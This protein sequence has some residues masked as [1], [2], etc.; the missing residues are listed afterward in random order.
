LLSLLRIVVSELSW[1]KKRSRFFG[2]HRRFHRRL[3][4]MGIGLFLVKT[5]VVLLGG[6]ISN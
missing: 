2:L 1:L 4:G 5:Q 3:E 6:K